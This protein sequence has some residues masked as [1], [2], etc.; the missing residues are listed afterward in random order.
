M[1]CQVTRW[2]Q[3]QGTA[4]HTQRPS[5]S[6]VFLLN[7]QCPKF[8]SLTLKSST[9]S[10]LHL[11]SAQSLWS[12]F[13]TWLQINGNQ[14]HSGLCEHK[15]CDLILQ[16]HGSIA[17]GRKRLAYS[18]VGISKDWSLGHQRPLQFPPLSV[19]DVSLQVFPFLLPLSLNGY[20][21]TEFSQQAASNV[22]RASCPGVGLVNHHG[23][24]NTAI[25]HRRGTTFSHEDW[26]MPKHNLFLKFR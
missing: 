19:I 6:G 22:S 18:P 10:W 26:V 20:S 25:S 4:G 13:K 17:A 9:P 16:L 12:T 24:S 15:S 7:K 14:F 3:E 5:S 11:M 23:D 21:L 8:V 1:S 2:R